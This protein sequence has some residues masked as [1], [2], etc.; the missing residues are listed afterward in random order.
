M[1][2]EVKR[3]YRELPQSLTMCEL[4]GNMYWK[5]K[6][7]VSKYIAGMVILRNY[8]SFKKRELSLVFQRCRD[9]KKIPQQQ[10][11]VTEV[12]DLSIQEDEENILNASEQ[13]F[14]LY[15]N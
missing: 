11:Q 5:Y 14:T 2:R 1:L 15:L 12:I 8:R 3:K 4:T 6:M 10:L 9:G 13:S 7:N